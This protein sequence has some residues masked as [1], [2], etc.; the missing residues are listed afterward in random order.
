[1]NIEYIFLPEKVEEVLLNYPVLS[2]KLNSPYNEGQS[3][4]AFPKARKSNRQIYRILA[5]QHFPHLVELLDTL[6][7]CISNG[8]QNPALS[9]TRGRSQF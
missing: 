6:E 9:Q 2:K 1:M 8:Y 4:T 7:F 3:S 5:N